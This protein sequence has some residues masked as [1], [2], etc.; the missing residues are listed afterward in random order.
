MDEWDVNEDLPCRPCC[1]RLICDSCEK[2]IGTNA[3]CPLCRAPVAENFAEALARI[4]RQVDEEI[5]EAIHMLGAIY[6]RGD[7]GVVKSTKKA[8]NSVQRGRGTGFSR[9]SDSRKS[10]AYFFVGRE[11]LQARCGA[12]QFARDDESRRAVLSWR[13]CQAGPAEGREAVSTRCGLLRRT[14]RKGAI[15]PRACSA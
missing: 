6:E 3:A 9:D 10:N 13:W 2:K 8:A 4:R 15:Q 14:C 5:P 1:C 11:A 7:L 12:R